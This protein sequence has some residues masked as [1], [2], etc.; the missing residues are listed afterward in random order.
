[1][2]CN[3][4]YPKYVHR[5]GRVICCIGVNPNKRYDVTPQT[6][7]QILRDMLSGG[8]SADDNVG[9]RCKNVQVEGKQF[10]RRRHWSMVILAYA[11]ILFV[12]FFYCFIFN[13]GHRL[14]MEIRQ[15][16]K[17]HHLL[18]WNTNLVRR[19]TRWTTIT[20]T[21]FMGTTIAWTISV[22]STNNILGGWSKVSTC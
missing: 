2:L 1:M 5:Y 15:N 7:A 4:I 18:P 20:N 14:H 10:L 11:L 19:W 6:R 13:S 9:S 16:S 3:D 8:I 22:A 21:K 12:L 17:C